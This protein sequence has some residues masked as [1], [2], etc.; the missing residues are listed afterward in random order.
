MR[1]L[2]DQD[3]AVAVI[4]GILL[5]V[6]LGIGALVVDVGNLYWERRQLQTGAEA[7][8]LS[9]AQ[10]Y[11]SGNGGAAEAGAR[12]YAN[13][14]DARGAFVSAFAPNLAAQEVSVTTRTGSITAEGRL[15]SWLAQM[16]GNPDY[17]ATATATARWGGIGGG[18]TVPLTFSQ[19]EWEQMTGGDVANLPTGQR[20]VY[21]HSSQTAKNINSC[22]GPANQDHPGGFGWLNPNGPGCSSIVNL[23]SVQTDAGNNV[24]NA[25]SE[26]Y[27]RDL[28]GGPP[29]LLPIFGSVTS[30]GSKATFQIVGFA[31]LE[32]TGYRFSGNKFNEP[33][34]GVPCGGDDRCIR[35]NFVAYYALDAVPSIG[36]PSFGVVSV[37]LTG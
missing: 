14:N 2:N 27:L 29:V 7:A 20:T 13:A 28:I 23:G 3:G 35:G 33:V 1:R 18:A 11:A 26:E 22:G 6:L 17:F 37:Q 34:G 36:A 19:C 25:C 15:A 10:D 12:N 30:Q 21:F 31:A 9:A 4:V 32:V 16:I 5:V 8:A 24:P